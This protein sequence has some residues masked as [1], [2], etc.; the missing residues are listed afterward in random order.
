MHGFEK[1]LQALFQEHLCTVSAQRH[2]RL[3][4]SLAPGSHSQRCILS[5]CVPQV[6]G[7]LHHTAAAEEAP[8]HSKELLQRAVGQ[9]RGL[10]S[11]VWA[12]LMALL[13]LGGRTSASA[14]VLTRSAAKPL[15]C[16]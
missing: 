4:V 6:H 5:S 12:L 15:L 8:H 10:L 14:Q 9:A 2:L 7:Y 16:I 3:H 11:R 1:S 13:G